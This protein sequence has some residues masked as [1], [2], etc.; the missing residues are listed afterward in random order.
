MNQ[1]VLPRKTKQ[2]EKKE[3]NKRDGYSTFLISLRS[4]YD[5]FNFNFMDLAFMFL[6]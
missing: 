5:P 4:F 1:S 2:K 6:K 3:D